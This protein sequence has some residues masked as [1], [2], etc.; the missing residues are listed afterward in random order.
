MTIYDDLRNLLSL[1]G[2]D[3]TDYDENKLNALLLESKLI[4]N[5]PFT[6]DTVHKD[7]KQHFLGDKY[8][9][10]SYPLKEVVS[11]K[12]GEEEVIPEH[13]SSNGIIY[14]EKQVSGKLLVEYIVGLTS[15]DYQDTVLPICVYLAKDIAGQN[16]SSISE[17]DVSVSYAAGSSATMID[18]LVSEIRSKYGARVRLL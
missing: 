11:V 2:I 6:T 7:Y 8:L 13:V 15:Q 18:N 9:T 4:I 1:H 12:I 14:F 10:E 5:A 17:G 16:V 3:T